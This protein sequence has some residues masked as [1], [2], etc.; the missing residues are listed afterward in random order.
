[1]V[2]AIYLKPIDDRPRPLWRLNFK[3]L[4]K[5]GCKMYNAPIELFICTQAATCPIRCTQKAAQRER[6]DYVREQRSKLISRIEKLTKQNGNKK[7]CS[8]E[9]LV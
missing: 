8:V 9:I 7:N 3:D 2:A 4:D 5:N 6:E 1:M